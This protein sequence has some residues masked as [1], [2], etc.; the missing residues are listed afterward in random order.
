MCVRMR[1]RSATNAF[2]GCSLSRRASVDSGRGRRHSRC[3]AFAPRAVTRR[4]LAEAM[5]TPGASARSSRIDWHA[6]ADEAAWVGA[7]S[8][9]IHAALQAALDT[10]AETWLLLS[11]GTTPAPVYRA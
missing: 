6:H 9:A 7:A 8:G 2:R 4:K 5:P 10:H 3:M 1:S 11:G